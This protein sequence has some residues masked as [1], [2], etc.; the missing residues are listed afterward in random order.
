MDSGG[1]V[2]AEAA[3]NSGGVATVRLGI[4]FGTANTVGVI[5][6]PG[7]EPRALL[8]NGT[9][10]LPSAVQATGGGR[11]LVGRDAQHAAVTDPGAFEPHPKR[12]IDDGTVLLGDSETPVTALIAAV[13]ARVSGEAARV[14]DGVPA[15]TI[16]TVPAAWG[17][18]RRRTLLDAAAGLPNVR[19][20]A[21][22]VAAAMYYVD[23]AGS[24]VPAGRPVMVFDF[25][26]GTFDATVIRRTE[27]GFDV[28]ATEGLPDCGGLDIDA[29][30]VAYLGTLFASR[31]EALWHRLDRPGS[32]PDRRA[33][34][35][36]WDGVREAKEMLTEHPSA[37]IH[38]PL[39]DVEVPLG[40]EQLDALA[41]PIIDRTVAAC[42]AVLSTAGVKP[43]D[44]AAVLLTGGAS[45]MPA[46][47]TA[48]HRALGLPP[49][50]VDQP[51]LAVAEGSVR[52]LDAAYETGTGA[53]WPGPATIELSV[54]PTPRPGRQFG[55][56]P[57]RRR[58]A[59]A[60]G[61]L[62]LLVAAGVGIALLERHPKPPGGAGPSGSRA[63]ALA[64]ASPS[65]TTSPSVSVPPGIDPC[66]LGTWSQT[67]MQK[68]NTIDG[69]TVPFVGGAGDV[70]TFNASGRFT[71]DFTSAAP[72]VAVV[73]G[74][75]WQETTRGQSAGTYQARNGLLL[76]ANITSSGAWTITRNGKVRN[77]GMTSFS[78]EPEPYVC[79]GD[80]L[81]IAASFYTSSWKRVGPPPA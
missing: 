50:A 2:D 34:R 7:R 44:L 76:Y 81:T 5:A 12:C 63:A 80:D 69:R 23:I 18:E 79:N 21:E 65:A 58:L 28:L 52:M 39:F 43:S 66:L 71:E 26:A 78:V 62:T 57:R 74:A 4:D 14:A 53:A 77:S 13:L 55:A 73:S 46:V 27:G 33:A 60:A 59:V 49:T 51:E 16:I 56:W 41:A 17:Q 1:S 10:L 30:I 40:R 3:G 20:V 47:S 9:P 45:R 31:D 37:L 67:Q 38:V 70:R 15:E 35:Q 11:L 42:L 32:T 25:G 22:P 29:A 6:L 64:G 68:Q 48:L 75:T 61:A 54:D 24:R 36:L 19:L 8:F 72:I